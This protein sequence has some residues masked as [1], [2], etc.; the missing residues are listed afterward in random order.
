MLPRWGPPE[1]AAFGQPAEVV[2]VHESDLGPR[3]H[4][5]DSGAQAVAEDQVVLVEASD[6]LP[7]AALDRRV[8]RHGVPGV[9]GK[10]MG[11]D[12]CV[13]L[14]ECFED[15]PG[16]IR[17]TIVDRDQLEVG[18][19]LP[20]HAAQ[21]ELEVSRAVEHRHHDGD[22]RGVPPRRLGNGMEDAIDCACAAR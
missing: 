8:R 6:E 19:R 17:R 7:A 5:L 13:S 20:Q 15:R 21:R 11:L 4:D 14:S 10:T 12:T 22:Q 3:L 16:L 1:E 18:E 9:A 2:G